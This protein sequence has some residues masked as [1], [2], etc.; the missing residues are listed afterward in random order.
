MIIE[1]ITV[2][3][4]NN[5]KVTYDE[6]GSYIEIHY[7]RTP[8]DK[9]YDG[10]FVHDVFIRAKESQQD[11][12]ITLNVERYLFEVK[13][14]ES[15]DERIMRWWCGFSHNLFIPMCAMCDCCS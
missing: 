4:E 15:I 14:D 5:F 8:H 11:F 1:N 6:F 13:N 10:V 7:D 9:E 12:C 3:T 2:K